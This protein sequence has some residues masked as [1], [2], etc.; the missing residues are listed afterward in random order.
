MEKLIIEV[1]IIP[2][3]KNGGNSIMKEQDGG[4]IDE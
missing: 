4:I 3:V 1:Q 2:I